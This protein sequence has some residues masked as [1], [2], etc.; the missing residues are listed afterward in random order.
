[1]TEHRFKQTDAVLVGKF[2]EL[3]QEEIRSEARESADILT[4]TLGKRPHFFA[5]PFGARSA[6]AEHAIENTGYEAAF[7]ITEGL[8][9]QGDNLFRLK[10]VQIDDT[11]SFFLFRMRLT[12]ALEWNRRMVDWARSMT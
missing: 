6:D 9:H 7:G 5:Y 2:T 12:A 11:M 10:R 3:L 4:R 1:M 8:I